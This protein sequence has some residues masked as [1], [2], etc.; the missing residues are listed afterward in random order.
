VRFPALEVGCSHSGMISAFVESAEPAEGEAMGTPIRIDTLLGRS[1][2]ELA[3]ISARQQRAGC[4]K[5][6]ARRTITPLRLGVASPD[7]A[8][9]PLRAK[10]IALRDGAAGAMAAARRPSKTHLKS[11]VRLRRGITTPTPARSETA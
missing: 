10:G 9:A 7:L 5:G 1:S 2:A 3:E 11:V 6:V 8:V 4:R